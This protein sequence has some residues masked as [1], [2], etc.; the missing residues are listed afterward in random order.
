MHRTAPR[1]RLTFCVFA[2][3]LLAAKRRL[4]GLAVADLILVR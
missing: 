2:I 3:N 1:V 4:I